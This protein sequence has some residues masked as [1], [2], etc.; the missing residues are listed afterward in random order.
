VLL[1][2][3]FFAA[4]LGVVG[5]LNK[6]FVP[7]QDQG[8]FMIR[9]QAPVDSSLAFTD[10]KFNPMVG[11]TGGRAIGDDA[12]IWQMELCSVCC[13][14]GIDPLHTSSAI[15][16]ASALNSVSVLSERPKAL[17]M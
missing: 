13:A 5:K 11:T 16:S 8:N 10:S 14:C 6:E 15:T 17:L 1:G 4:S 3:G 2:V 12:N 9:L 7:A